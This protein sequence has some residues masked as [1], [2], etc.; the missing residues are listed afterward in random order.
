MSSSTSRTQVVLVPD[1]L[2]VTSSGPSRQKKEME[3]FIQDSSSFPSTPHPPRPSVRDSVIKAVNRKGE[4]A[5]MVRSAPAPVLVMRL[6]T[7]GV[8]RQSRDHQLASAATGGWHCV[9][10]IT[11][12]I[13]P[14]VPSHLFNSGAG[15]CLPQG[16]THSSPCTY[17]QS[18]ANGNEGSESQQRYNDILTIQRDNSV[19]NPAVIWQN[20]PMTDMA[21]VTLQRFIFNVSQLIN[22]SQSSF[23]FATF[24]GVH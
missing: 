22:F 20:E 3:M 15:G 1:G 19:K 7:D 8:Q 6:D 18:K 23:M 2:C 24:L 12:K 9:F 14:G 11:A 21:R 5:K 17:C 13:S 16:S 10:L 4:Q